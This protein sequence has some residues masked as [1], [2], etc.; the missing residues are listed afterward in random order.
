MNFT[1]VKL[2]DANQ[3]WQP[4]SNAR[5]SFDGELEL[6]FG[7]PIV[8]GAIMKIPIQSQWFDEIVGLQFTLQWNETGYRFTGFESKD[9]ADWQT[10]EATTSTGNLPIM[11]MDES[12]RGVSLKDES[13]LAYLVLE[14]LDA[15]ADL[16][17]ELNSGITPAVAYDIH[18]SSMRIK[19][20][21][22]NKLAELKTSDI[23]VYP[24]P[25]KDFIQFKGLDSSEAYEYFIVNT[26]GK[27]IKQGELGAENMISLQNLTPGLY[28][29]K[30]TDSVGHV[31][32]NEIIKQ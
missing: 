15:S 3:N 17:L 22:L 1:A 7:A 18:L 27:Q 9:L 16:G 31:F 8:D 6:N 32:T 30:V 13:T 20:E 25:A 24:N 21:G 11:W 19:S 26:L 14:Q 12:I 28:I 5:E 2:G 23:T 29:L 10:N 4:N